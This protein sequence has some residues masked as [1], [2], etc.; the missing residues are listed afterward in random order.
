M[1]GAAGRGLGLGLIAAAIKFEDGGPVLYHQK[2]LGLNEVPKTIYKFRSM[3]H[4][5]DNAVHREYLEKFVKS[6]EPADNTTS[7]VT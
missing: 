2:V 1:A 4:N 5:S 3:T 7:C 6:N